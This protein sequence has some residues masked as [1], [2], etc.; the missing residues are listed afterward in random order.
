MRTDK[1]PVAR[2]DISDTSCVSKRSL[3][4][5]GRPN[6]SSR[7]IANHN[8]KICR[9]NSIGEIRTTVF[10]RKHRPRCVGCTEDPEVSSPKA[11]RCNRFTTSYT[12]ISQVDVSHTRHHGCD[13]S[14]RR[15]TSA[16]PVV[17]IAPASQQCF[18]IVICHGCDASHRF[19]SPLR[20]S[21]RPSRCQG[22]TQS[23]QHSR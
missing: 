20:S 23:A 19:S 15:L 18:R 16:T 17:L 7:Q 11:S 1:D 10:R 3:K 14:E 12:L 4:F 5:R 9:S 6:F 22:C 2:H 21:T 8:L 13:T